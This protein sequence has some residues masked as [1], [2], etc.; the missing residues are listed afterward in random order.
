MNERWGWNKFSR[1]AV[2][3]WSVAS[4]LSGKPQPA[5]TKARADM[6][7]KELVTLKMAEALNGKR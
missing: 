2:G 7:L 4:E 3:P 1:G 5:A 6:T